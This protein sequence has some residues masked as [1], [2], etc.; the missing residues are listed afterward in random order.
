MPVP[1]NFISTTDYATFKN[2]NHTSS[3]VTF[4]GSIN[5]GGAAT[6]SQTLNIAIGQTGAINRIQISSSKD[7]NRRYSTLS[8][9]YSRNGS[10]GGSPASY[11]I[12]VF[13]SRTSNTNLTLTVY[14]A[15]PYNTTLTTEGTNETF[16][17]YVDTFIPPFV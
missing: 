8:L 15:N 6:Y 13:V 12:T 9:S 17:F 7:S 16:N 4:L 1:G 3:S 5:I 11:T 10:S 2:D 14:V